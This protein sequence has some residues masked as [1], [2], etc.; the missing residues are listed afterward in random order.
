MVATKEV[1]ETALIESCLLDVGLRLG[2]AEVTSETE[3]GMT[4][5]VHGIKRAKERDKIFCTSCGSDDVKSLRRITGY[6][7]DANRF[8]DGKS[9]EL[10]DR[11]THGG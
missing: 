3:E 7:S 10:K 4:F 1:S 8:N 11:V 5:I 6:L 9:A 2:V